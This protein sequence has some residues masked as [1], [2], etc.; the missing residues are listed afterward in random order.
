MN[1]SYSTKDNGGKILD[2]QVSQEW[3]CPKAYPDYKLTWARF[4]LYR[5]WLAACPTCTD[6]VM[7]TDVRDAFFQSGKCAHSYLK[8][9]RLDCSF[10]PFSS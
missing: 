6:G 8:H 3:H 5:D 10:I 2:T 7:L 1:E 4:P 9:T